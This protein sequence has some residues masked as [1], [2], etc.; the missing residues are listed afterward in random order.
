MGLELVEF[1]IS[2]EKRFEISMPDR[3]AS[4][5]TTPRKLIDYLVGRLC[6]GPADRQCRTQ[7]AFYRVRQTLISSIGAPR[8]AIRTRT[9][10]AA[11]LPVETRRQEW[12]RLHTT[13][14]VIEW[15]ELVRPQGLFALLSCITVSL[16][17]AVFLG[18]A[19]CFGFWPAV[20][21]ASACCFVVGRVLARA[22]V[23]FKREF[24][25]SYQTVGELTRFVFASTPPWFYSRRAC[26]TREHIRAVV[27][28]LIAE[29]LGVNLGADRN[30]EDLEW[31][32]DLGID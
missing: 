2:V 9:P 22:T 18:L 13:L 20:V 6:T 31:T 5:L 28:R 10:L 17:L 27:H 32:G 1:F 4:S 29:E 11:L 25:G 3:E 24:Q 8:E 21:M 23:S 14:G 30:A 15:P 12:S 7:Q 19:N 26:W 16:F